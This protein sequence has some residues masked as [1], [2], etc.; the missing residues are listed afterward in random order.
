MG[1]GLL[2]PG[3][4]PDIGDPV[5]SMVSIIFFNCHGGGVTS[6]L[7]FTGVLGLPVSR[8]KVTREMRETEYSLEVVF[9]MTPELTLRPPAFARLSDMIEEEG[10]DWGASTLVLSLSSL[11]GVDSLP[12]LPTRLCTLQI[13]ER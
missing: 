1:M 10:L 4:S 3:L 5:F 12:L 11:I 8:E 7:S 2:T 13:Q 6:F 9:S